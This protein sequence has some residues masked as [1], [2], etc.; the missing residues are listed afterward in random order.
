MDNS[1][2][3]ENIL[4]RIKNLDYK[5]G[6]YVMESLAKH[7]K[8]KKTEINSSSSSHLLTELSGLGSEIWKNVD[9]DQYIRNERQWD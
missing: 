2:E 8:K 5:A 1:I 6:L 3:I 4:L 7:L 9:I